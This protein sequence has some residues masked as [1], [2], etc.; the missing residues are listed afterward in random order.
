MISESMASVLLYLLQRDWFLKA[1]LTYEFIIELNSL[2]NQCSSA[3]LA[4]LV[5]N[6]TNLDGNL[7]SVASI[8]HVPVLL[9]PLN[10]C[11]GQIFR[12]Y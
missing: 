4:S 5:L 12:S 8:T 9:W 6:L 11:I 2:N 1:Y 3:S 7:N 10:G